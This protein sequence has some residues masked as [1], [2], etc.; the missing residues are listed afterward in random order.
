[1]KRRGGSHHPPHA[2]QPLHD[3]RTMHEAVWTEERARAVLDDPARYARED[4]SK[5]WKR[6]GLSVGMRVAEVGAGSG[7][8]AFPASDRVGPTGRV[9][10]IDISPELI[11]MVRARARREH[12]ANVT[13]T[14]SRAGRIPLAGEIVDRLLLA[15]VL[16]GI[17][18]ATVREA[19]RLLKPGGRLVVLDW[20]KES[21]P[22]GPP[23]DHR[24][25]AAA[26]RRA[27]REHGLRSVDAWRPGPY[28]YA[29]MMEKPPASAGPSTA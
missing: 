16:H 3:H 22:Y 19:V 20:R 21:S 14:L 4:P 28:H 8:Y 15:N 11:R 24:L 5:L 13:A 6:A 1:M 9:Y 17:P 2:H 18:P 29:V 7:F 23:V 10:A 12:R 25:S 26:A 27:L